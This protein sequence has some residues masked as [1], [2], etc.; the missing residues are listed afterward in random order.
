MESNTS[1]ITRKMY[2]VVDRTNEF[3]EFDSHARTLGELQAELK[4]IGIDYSGCSFMEASTL[5]TYEHPDSVLPQEVISQ[6]TGQRTSD[7]SFLLVAKNKNINSGRSSSSVSLDRKKACGLIKENG[8]EDSFVK[9]YGKKPSGAKT[10]DIYNF[11]VEVKLDDQ[12]EVEKLDKFGNKIKFGKSDTK[13]EK[14]ALSNDSAKRVSE[15]PVSKP[16]E[17]V[18]EEV[19][20]EIESETVGDGVEI[21]DE[22]TIGESTVE[23]ASKTEVQPTKP[24]P[25]KK[26]AEH[27]AP[28]EAVI[29][30]KCTA[31]IDK[32]GVAVYEIFKKEATKEDLIDLIESQSE[33]IQKEI[34]NSLTDKLI[35]K[36]AYSNKYLQEQLNKA[37]RFKK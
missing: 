16:K 37:R 22:S 27:S 30:N 18:E 10:D 8:F 31:L 12:I 26:K 32:I 34:M 35:P 6:E 2:I 14:P 4:A 21:I 20:V 24:E 5:A 17:E 19:R 1:E 28:I 9:K 13:A 7:L 11:L 23:L 29:G 25:V 3:R 15:K 36:P 33:D